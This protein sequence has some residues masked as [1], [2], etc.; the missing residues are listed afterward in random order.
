M[1]IDESQWTVDKNLSFH[2]QRILSTC[3]QYVVDGHVCILNAFQGFL[4]GDLASLSFL[5]KIKEN[6]KIN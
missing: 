3:V 6:R 2:L 5:Y 1:E 4:G